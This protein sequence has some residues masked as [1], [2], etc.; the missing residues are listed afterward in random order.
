MERV[1]G[2]ID[3]DCFFVQVEQRPLPECAGKPAAVTQYNTYK[4]GG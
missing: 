3:M 1:I 4:G 2:L